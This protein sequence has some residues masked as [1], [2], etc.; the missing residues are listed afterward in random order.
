[1]NKIISI[2]FLHLFIIILIITIY[3]LIITYPIE[4]LFETFVNNAICDKCDRL[5]TS[6]CNKTSCCV[7]LHDKCVKG[8]VNGPSFNT[9]KNGKTIQ[10]SYY[11]QNKC[12]GDLCV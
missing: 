1:M 12:Y 10:S 8:N 6:N 5:T 2:V 4:S 11:F 3:L 9:D 7:W